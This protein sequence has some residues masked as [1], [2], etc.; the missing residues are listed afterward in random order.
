MLTIKQAYPNAEKQD[1]ARYSSKC[2]YMYAE[3]MHSLE[4]ISNRH[5]TQSVSP[6]ILYLRIYL[7]NLFSGAKHIRRVLRYLEKHDLV[8]RWRRVGLELELTDGDLDIIQRNRDSVEDRAAG[9]LSRWLT[10]GGATKQALVE[11]VQ[12]IT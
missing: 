9:M 11:A 3:E 7:Y 8:S 4:Q 6:C 10:S 2:M 5:S 12:E 1:F